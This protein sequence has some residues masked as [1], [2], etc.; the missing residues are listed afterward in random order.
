MDLRVNAKGKDIRV[1]DVTMS[2]IKL[3]I[4]IRQLPQEAFNIDGPR[5]QRL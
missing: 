1:V 5:L 3:P 2:V 4:E